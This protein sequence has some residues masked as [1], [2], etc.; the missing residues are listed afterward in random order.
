VLSRT[1]S[2]GALA[3]AAID[4]EHEITRARRV[5]HH[6][7]ERVLPSYHDALVVPTAGS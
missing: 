2:R 5:L 4:V 7:E 6:L 1:W 3:I